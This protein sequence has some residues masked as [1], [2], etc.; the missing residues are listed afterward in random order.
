MD[1]DLISFG[2]CP[3]A[4]L[5]LGVAVDTLQAA[6]Y[7]YL[8]SSTIACFGIIGWTATLGALDYHTTPPLRLQDYCHTLR[9]YKRS[10][11]CDSMRRHG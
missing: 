2:T 1:L 6:M 8:A 3:S 7:E 10:T 5:L 11:L 4:V 9:R